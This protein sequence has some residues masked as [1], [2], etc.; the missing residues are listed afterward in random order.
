MSCSDLYTLSLFDWSIS[1][2]SENVSLTFQLNPILLR[3]EQ[4]KKKNLILNTKLLVKF[5]WKPEICFFNL[6][7][8]DRAG[9][10]YTRSNCG[11]PLFLHKLK[12]ARLFIAAMDVLLV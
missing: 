1:S 9:W 3:G 5:V 12:A 8:S 7:Q 6:M 2:F 10:M 11:K 4:K